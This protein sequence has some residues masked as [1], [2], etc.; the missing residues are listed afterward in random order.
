MW[1]QIFV[2]SVGFEPTISCIRGN[3]LPLDHK[4]LTVENE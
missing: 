1:K 4:G 2:P 3:V